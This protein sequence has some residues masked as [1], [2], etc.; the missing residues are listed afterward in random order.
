[1]R[2]SLTNTDGPPR[3]LAV[4]AH[5]DDETFGCG[6][7]LLHAGSSGMRTVVVCA[8]RREAG[9][10]SVSGDLGRLREEELR[11]AASAL[12]VARV[13]VLGFRDSGMAG[14]AGPE[15]LVGAPLQAVIEQ[16][17]ARIEDVRPQVVVTLDG[18]DGHRDHVRIRDATLAAV[19]GASRPVERVYLQCL[20]KSLMAR[21][22]AHM[23]R[24]DPSWEHLRSDPPGTPDELIST[25]IDT[26]RFLET[27]ERAIALHASQK[28]PFAGLPDD[29]RA[30]FLAVEHLR[31]VRPPW[32]SEPV[33]HDLGF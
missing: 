1:V 24:T 21:W 26:A 32:S 15:T 23:A 27:R 11:A 18:G 14:D 5:P 22:I 3:L 4:V 28:S 17:R 13:E 9:E 7:L 6:S 8:T 10:A 31:R 2:A 25:V 29:L 12:G 33:E 30:E 20:P 19:D 16:V